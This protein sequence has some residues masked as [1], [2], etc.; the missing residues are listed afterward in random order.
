MAPGGSLP[1]LYPVALDFV[2]PRRGW[3]LTPGGRLYATVDGGVAWR[4]VP[5]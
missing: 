1:S 4:Q 2:S 5:G 3:L